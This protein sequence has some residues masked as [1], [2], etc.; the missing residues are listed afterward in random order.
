MKTLVFVEHHEGK[1]QKDSLGVLG[2]AASLGGEVEAVVLGEGVEG[3]AAEAGKYGAS[4]VHVADDVL[5]GTAGAGELCV[6]L[7]PHQRQVRT[8]QGQ[9]DARDQQ[10]VQ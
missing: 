8:D 10:D 1:L 2:K 5:L 7:E 6:L 3:L 9:D 4:R